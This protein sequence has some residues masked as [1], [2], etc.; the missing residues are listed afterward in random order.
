VPQSCK[1]PE[2]VNTISDF[3]KLDKAN[4]AVS[5]GR[6]DLEALGR[7]CDGD[8]RPD[9]IGLGEGVGAESSGSGFVDPCVGEAVVVGGC[10]D[11]PE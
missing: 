3:A 11:S 6:G 1:S 2:R 4:L 5:L 10:A 9:P 7:G 8:V